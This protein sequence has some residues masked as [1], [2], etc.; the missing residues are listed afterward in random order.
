MKKP[1][2]HWITE[3]DRVIFWLGLI[4]CALAS[5]RLYSDNTPIV[6]IF[7]IN[8]VFLLGIAS[9]IALL[10]A[11]LLNKAARRYQKECDPEIFLREC[12]RQIPTQKP[13]EYKNLLLINYYTSQIMLGEYQKA[14][15]GLLSITLAS[16]KKRPTAIHFAYCNNLADV[17]DM[18]G[19]VESANHWYREATEIYRSFSKSY[20]LGYLSV[21]TLLEAQNCIRNRIDLDRA[22]QLLDRMSATNEYQRVCRAFTLAQVL[23]LKN[24]PEQ[25]RVHLNYVIDHGNK[26]ALVSEARELLKGTEQL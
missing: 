22:L 15:D 17:Y 8:V 6:G 9:A 5:W 10:R 4:P 11:H 18:L 25:A 13:C 20:Q 14:L 16:P 2:S 3:N 19:Q 24:E 1:I 26:L 12:A 21:F 7:L 23:L